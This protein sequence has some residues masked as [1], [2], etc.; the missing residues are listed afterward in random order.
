MKKILLID[1]N[2]DILAVVEEVLSYE[3]F[4]V[5]SARDDVNIMAIAEKF[6][7]DLIITDYRLGS[8]NGGELC[9]QFKVH[10]KLAQVPVIIFSAY[11]HPNSDF[12]K[13]GC[14]AVIEKPFDLDDLTETISRL[15]GEQPDLA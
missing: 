14:D 2:E 8:T 6:N 11:M 4:E 3:K 13:Y 12:F 9:Q 10:P 7:P 1:D 5:L 15:I